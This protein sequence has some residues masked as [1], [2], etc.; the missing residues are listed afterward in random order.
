MSEREQRKRDDLIFDLSK[1][2]LPPLEL[3][4]PPKREMKKLAVNIEPDER[5]QVKEDYKVLQPKPSFFS[6]L[7]RKRK[8]ALFQKDGSSTP[9]LV[10]MYDKH[11]SKEELDA[12]MVAGL[13]EDK[14]YFFAEIDGKT[15]A[16]KSVMWT[17]KRTVGRGKFALPP[18]KRLPNIIKESL[19]PLSSVA[20]AF[21]QIDEVLTKIRGGGL[22]K[23]DVASI[24]E[25]KLK[26]GYGNPQQI[27]PLSFAGQAPWWIHPYVTMQIPQM[28]K[29]TTSQVISGIKEGIA[30]GMQ[31]AQGG[32][33]IQL[34]S[35]QNIMQK[36]PPKVET[37][38]PQEI[39]P[40]EPTPEPITTAPVQEITVSAPP[41][42]TITPTQPI[43]PEELPAEEI[44]P[45]PPPE[46]PKRKR[47]VKLTKEQK[48]KL[49]EIAER[50]T[51]EVNPA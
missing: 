3:E 32:A 21:Q 23:E 29:E 4:L 8:Y 14:A 20:D 10:S 19:E 17:H 49:K 5:E 34:P 39:K 42:V 45:E 47:K 30:G 31:Q 48:E 27:P 40:V 18:W 33:E 50:P 28:V 6:S 43:P 44:K 22:T 13:A 36:A 2:E 38:P 51:E 15:N 46:K 41:P 16:V 11:Y 37:A 12:L 1:K 24:I 7:G 35:L 25:E 9:L 26:G